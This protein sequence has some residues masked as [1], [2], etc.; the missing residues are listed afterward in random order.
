ML[1]EEGASLVLTA[2]TVSELEAVAESCRKK[3]SPAVECRSCDLCLG[4]AVQRL[5]EDIL[6]R[7]G[8]VEVLVNNGDCHFPV[9]MH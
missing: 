2:R 5:A 3:G 9:A 7:H 6:A 8:G 4:D 1:A